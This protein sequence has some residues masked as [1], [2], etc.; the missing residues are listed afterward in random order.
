MF[1]GFRVQ[2][3]GSGSTGEMNSPGPMVGII[4]DVGGVGGE[5]IASALD[6]LHLSKR[7]ASYGVELLD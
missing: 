1:S 7:N 5:R 2:G 3:Q 6:R 4:L